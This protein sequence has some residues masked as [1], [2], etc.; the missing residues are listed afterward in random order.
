MGDY[1]SK[2]ASYL[3]SGSYLVFQTVTS[4]ILP[5]G[6]CNSEGAEGA[7]EKTVMAVWV[8]IT[9]FTC[10]MLSFTDSVPGEN[11]Q[12]IYILLWPSRTGYLA[13]KPLPPLLAGAFARGGKRALGVADLGHAI[14]STLTLA[15][16]ALLTP[17]VSTCLFPNMPDVVLRAVPTMMFAAALTF[18]NFFGRSRDGMGFTTSQAPRDA[19]DIDAFNSLQAGEA[20][21]D[22]HS[23]AVKDL[24][25]KIQALNKKQLAI[26]RGAA[27]IRLQGLASAGSAGAGGGTAVTTPNPVSQLAGATGNTD[28]LETPL[29]GEQAAATE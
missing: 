5:Q 22:E 3:P 28:S 10:F 6:N 1:V 14:L 15:T 26:V 21:G 23:V 17:P 20:Q 27:Q 29:L 16:L 24:A 8:G 19:A 13:Q 12:V 18:F 9:L 7:A 2:V 25:T 4:L 11:G